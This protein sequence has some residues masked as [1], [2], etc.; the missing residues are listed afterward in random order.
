[1]ETPTLEPAQPEVAETAE[2]AETEEVA[3]PTTSQ[4]SYTD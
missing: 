2:V 4:W 3:E 1:M